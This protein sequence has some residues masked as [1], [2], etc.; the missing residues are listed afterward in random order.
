MI[1]WAAV[2]GDITLPSVV[3]FLII[4][5]WTPPHFWALALYKQGDYGAAGIPMLPNVA[6]EQATKVQIVV[7]TII[8]VAT[9]LV[10]SFIGMSGALYTA[11]AVVTGAAFLYLS[12]RLHRA[13]DTA[14]KKVARSVFTF[15]LSYLFV[16][17][18][19]LITD[20][21]AQ[22]AGWL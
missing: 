10:P 16:I 5:L 8:L 14:M 9:T 20:R 1:G 15:S 11:V 4:F 12:L 6:G 3:L 7:Y 21:V 22:A 18:L 13:T 2:T 19:A 17:F